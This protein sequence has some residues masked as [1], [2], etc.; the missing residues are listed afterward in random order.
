MISQFHAMTRRGWMTGAG[1]AALAASAE[2]PRLSRTVRIAILGFDGHPEEILRPLPQLPDVEVVAVSDPDPKVTARAVK[3][4]RLAKARQYTDYRRILDAEKLDLVAV[5]NPNGDRAEAILACVARKLNVIA[6]KPLAV[7]WRDLDRVKKAVSESGIKLGML[8]PMR[9]SPSYL[10]LKKI[11]EAG[12]IGE[13]AQIAAQKSYKAGERPAWM[14]SRKTYGGTIPWIGIHMID[15]M[16]FTSGREM[17]AVASFQTRIAFPE[18]GDMENVTGSLF[19]LDNSGIGT[20]RMDYLRPQ[21]APTHGDDRLRLAGTKGVAEYQAD[22]GVTLMSDARKPE[23]IREL[24]PEGSVFLDYVQYA[25]NGAAP[26]LTLADIYRTNEI[27]LGA[28][29]AAEKGEIV[30]L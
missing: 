8:L 15:L 16:R 2:P 6:E 5:C 26:T 30:R 23:T 29:D 25:Y 27:V 3:N 19:K 18:I 4:P 10:A 12:E 21:T 11:V 14:R 7:E 24:P 28:R 1:G 22:T 17:T 9:Y 20:L 13:V